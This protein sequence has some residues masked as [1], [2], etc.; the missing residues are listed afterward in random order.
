MKGVRHY[1]CVH[2]GVCVSVITEVTIFLKVSGMCD[3]QA[4]IMCTVCTYRKKESVF[5]VGELSVTLFTAVQSVLLVYDLLVAVCRWT[6]LVETI[7]L[8]SVQQCRHAAKIVRLR[9]ESKMRERKESNYGDRA[10]R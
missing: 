2:V 3:K 4:L 6:G 9:G 1:S 7:L 10:A 5:K 8:T